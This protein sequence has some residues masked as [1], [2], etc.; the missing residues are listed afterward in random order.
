MMRY[1][2]NDRRVPNKRKRIPKFD[3]HEPAGLPDYRLMSRFLTKAGLEALAFKTLSVPHSNEEIVDKLELD[4]LRAYA[5][6]G[7][8]ETWPF[9]YRTLY[10]VNT[11]FEENGTHFE[12]LHEFDILCT[13]TMEFYFVLVLFGVEF[14]ANLGG[15]ELDGYQNWLKQHDWSSPLYK[16]VTR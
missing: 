15:P 8:G 16:T 10:P 3:D 9:A 6:Y 13:D 1:I 5:R 11:V 14:V 7:Q 2:R 12:L 4:P